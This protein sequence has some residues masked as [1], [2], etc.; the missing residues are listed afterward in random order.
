MAI[1]YRLAKAI[2]Q[3]HKYRP[4]RGTVLLVGRQTVTLTK[5]QAI[6]L[7]TDEG[8]PIRQ[9][10]VID[11]DRSTYG[12]EGRMLITDRTFFSLFSDA[13]VLA[14]DVSDY[15][16]A[17]IILD[18]N[19]PMPDELR[20]RADFMF[21]GSCLDNLFDPAS[22]LKNISRLL[23]PGGRIL[24]IEHGSPI[25]GA[26]VMY[27]PAFFSDYY[28]INGFADCKI[29]ACM[30]DKVFDAWNVFLWEP[31]FMEDG[32]WSLSDH[33]HPGWSNILNFVI[34]EK[35]QESACDRTPIQGF[36]RRA[37]GSS[38]DIYFQAFRN[39]QSSSRPRLQLNGTDS[40]N[41]TST[42]SKRGFTYLGVLADPVV[43]MQSDSLVQIELARQERASGRIEKAIEAFTRAIDTCADVGYPGLVF[44]ERGDLYLKK[45]DFKQALRDYDNAIAVNPDASFLQRKLD[46][47]KHI[48]K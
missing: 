31:F 38:D 15:E 41:G 16:N 40:T 45:G 1:D 6:D 44:V 21:N 10:A 33:M 9:D 46:I 42:P 18:L 8:V 22:A 34:A 23:K 37:H 13:E 47:L 48:E 43:Q 32:K 3:E 5:E 29:Y 39:F 27:S 28:A 36:Y 11:I 25:Q 14:M 24:H 2:L 7:I 17:E 30:F 35:G 4:I 20:S 26:Y 19:Q 12:S